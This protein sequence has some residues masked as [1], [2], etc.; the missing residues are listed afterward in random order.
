MKKK[1]SGINI[2]VSFFKNIG[3]YIIS[4]YSKMFATKFEK[5]VFLIFSNF[6]KHGL[7][8]SFEKSWICGKKLILKI[9][10]QKPKDLNQFRLCISTANILNYFKL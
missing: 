10:D 4:N 6:L 1:T 7:P 2:V 8:K 3:I 9:S 5:I